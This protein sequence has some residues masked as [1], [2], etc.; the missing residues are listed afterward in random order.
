MTFLINFI[1]SS[2]NNQL[3]FITILFITTNV[4]D[5]LSMISVPEDFVGEVGVLGQGK[6]CDND[7]ESWQKLLTTP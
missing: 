5:Y 7:Q 4:H 3:L 2:P 6:I 1:F